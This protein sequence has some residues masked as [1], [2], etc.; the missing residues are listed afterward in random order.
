MFWEA[1]SDLASVVVVVYLSWWTS[2]QQGWG[3]SPTFNPNMASSEGRVVVLE[4][5]VFLKSWSPEEACWNI[6]CEFGGMY[7]V[8][9]HHVY[10]VANYVHAYVP[11]NIRCDQCSMI[12]NRGRLETP[13][14]PLLL[15]KGESL[16]FC[17]VSLWS[18]ER[19][20]RIAKV[21]LSPL[22]RMPATTRI[23]I[24]YF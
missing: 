7:I 12:A 15:Q 20:T 17:R 10:H 23:I 2:P 1:A 9:I 13:K 21:G 3:T 24:L 22:P 16:G 6:V 5:C 8:L 19:K 11:H 18:F 14:P 4:S